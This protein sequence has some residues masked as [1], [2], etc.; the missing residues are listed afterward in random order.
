VHLT[1]ARPGRIRVSANCELAVRV[2]DYVAPWRASPPILMLHGLAESGEAFRQWV[3]HFAHRHVSFRPDLRG[4]GDSTAMPADFTYRFEELGQDIIRL[5][6][7]LQLERVFLIGFKIG[8]ALALHLTARYPERVI[9]TAA[10]AAP[11][12]LRSF[13]DRAPGW[14][15]LI[16]ERGV[17][18]WVRETTQWRLGS[19]LPP[20]AVEWWIEL[21]ARTPPSTLDAFLR[22]VP[23]VDVTDEVPLIRRPT[24]VITTTGSG[25]ASVDAV[26]EWQQTIPASKLEVLSSDSY[27]VGATHP[28]PCAQIVREFFESGSV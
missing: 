6:D 15:D 8:G 20:E 4:F 10:V 14:R 17:E 27:H 25:L 7:E 24:I 28:E 18:Q 2:D 11:V 22:M 12:S 3:P 9:A 21:M 13:S 1:L 19:S 26:K 16:R 23:T 5:L